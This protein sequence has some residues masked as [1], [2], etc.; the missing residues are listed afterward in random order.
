MSLNR[1]IVV[2]FLDAF[3]PNSVTITKAD[4]IPRPCKFVLLTASL[5]TVGHGTFHHV[6]PLA[7]QAR[8]SV[9]SWVIMS[10]YATRTFTWVTSHRGA[11]YSFEIFRHDL[12]WK[13]LFL[14]CHD[15]SQ[16]PQSY[17]QSSHLLTWCYSIFDPMSSPDSSY[18]HH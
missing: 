3:F 7:S 1:G 16:A 13:C 9:K 12:S 6:A 2:Y 17:E 10:S 11:L 18:V 8:D 5:L 14:F 15:A 4:R